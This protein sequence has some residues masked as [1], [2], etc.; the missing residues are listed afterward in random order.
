M[1]RK[2]KKIISIIVSI[3]LI[4][5]FGGV[6]A[7]GIVNYDKV[8]TGVQ[9]GNL[10]TKNDLDNSY[11]DGYTTAFADKEVLLQLINT[12]RATISQNEETI[13]RLEAE[14][15]DLTTQLSRIDELN[16]SISNLQNENE[17]LSS[18]IASYEEQLQN[19]KNEN[20]VVVK[21]LLRDLIY[22]VKVVNKG[23]VIGDIE[24]NDA[25]FNYWTIDGVRIDPT[26]YVANQDLEVV[27][28]FTD[29]YVIT[30][31]SG[32]NIV[33]KDFIKAGKSLTNPEQPQKVGFDF[34]GWS[35]NKTDVVDITAITP[36]SDMEFYAVFGTRHE[37]I[38]VNTSK[39]SVIDK[40]DGTKKMT[41]LQFY[42]YSQTLLEDGTYSCYLLIDDVL[43]AYSYKGDLTKGDFVIRSIVVD[44]YGYC[45]SLEELNKVKTEMIVVDVFGNKFKM[46]L[47]DT[48]S[49]LFLTGENLAALWSGRYIGLDSLTTNEI[50]T[51][52]FSSGQI[53]DLGQWIKVD[54][55]FT[56]TVGNAPILDVSDLESNFDE[57]YVFKAVKDTT[58]H[59]G[60]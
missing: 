19:V 24:I 12:H 6:L 1:K 14:K 7:W 54:F 8:K 60:N 59:A 20:Q 29:E 16:E 35:I 32:N 56:T 44:G 2:S 58:I 26:T 41:G 52:K 36:T 25:G 21:F 11:K 45:S 50:L 4:L 57:N 38:Y 48:F 33:H 5:A 46:T 22:D 51:S 9:G 13:T 53:Y 49:N 10:Y 39:F 15:K 3:V 47:S 18:V 42:S 30:Y 31:Y 37:D 28:N 55:T 23:S 43:I 27:A 34:L 40:T 17:R